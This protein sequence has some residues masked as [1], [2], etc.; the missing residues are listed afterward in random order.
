M[1]NVIVLREKSQ[2]LD[3]KRMIKIQEYFKST[4]VSYAFDPQSGS[5]LIIT[6]RYDIKIYPADEDKKNMITRFHYVNMSMDECYDQFPWF[7]SYE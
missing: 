2:Q 3:D 4:D 5:K 6:P 7:F 1:N